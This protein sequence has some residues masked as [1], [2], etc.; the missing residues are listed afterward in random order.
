MS[1]QHSHENFTHY[2]PEK[3]SG[4]K[5]FGVIFAC[6][7]VLAGIVRLYHDK[8]DAWWCFLGAVVFLFCAFFWHAPLKP[9]NH[10]W[11]TL[12]LALFSMTNPIL[13]GIIFFAAVLP[14]GLLMRAFRKDPLRIKH[15]KVA[16]SY[17]I[18][19]NPPGPT[20]NEMKNQF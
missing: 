20:G 19:R 12:G 8:A 13:M 14:T 1:R 4:E 18:Q 2:S 9:F 11:H 5:S 3:K 6:V 16:L 15:D 17:W 10:C 7:F